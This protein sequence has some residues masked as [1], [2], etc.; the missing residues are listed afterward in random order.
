MNERGCYCSLWEK[1]PAYLESE[2]IPH[3][4]CG[5]CDKCGQPGHT[6][7]FPGAVHFTG[8]WCDYHYR[9]LSIIHPLG[10]FGVL[11]YGVGLLAM[12]IG[13]WYFLRG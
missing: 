2:G 12:G 10:S 9:V 8:S 7:H 3:G 4:Y 5:L 13:L 6:R 1:N 11:L